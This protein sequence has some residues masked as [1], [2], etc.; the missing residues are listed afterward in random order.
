V[1][2]TLLAMI[3][4]SAFVASQNLYL[5]APYD[6]FCVDTVV[7]SKPWKARGWYPL[8]NSCYICLPYVGIGSWRSRGIYG[9]YAYN[10]L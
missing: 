3:Y 6:Y 8:Y 7:Y 2:V 4:D 5:I 1:D 10:S 9:S